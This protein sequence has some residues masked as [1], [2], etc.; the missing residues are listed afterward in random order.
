MI[1]VHIEHLLEVA[2]LLT[3][4]TVENGGK[5]VAIRQ[6]VEWHLRRQQ[7]IGDVTEDDARHVGVRSVHAVG[8]DRQGR[9]ERQRSGIGIRAHGSRPLTCVRV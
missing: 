7:A 2:T 8:I 3:D 9:D 6:A 1:G 5:L 4:E